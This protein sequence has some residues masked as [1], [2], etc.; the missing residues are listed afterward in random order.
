M[1]KD[2]MRI[3]AAES[4]GVKLFRTKNLV[5]SKYSSQGRE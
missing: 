5:S 2:T 1:L 3:Q 4:D